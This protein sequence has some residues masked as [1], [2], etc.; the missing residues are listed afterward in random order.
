MFR[1]N[2]LQAIL[3][4][5]VLAI[6]LIAGPT[7]A[8]VDPNG[9]AGPGGFQIDPAMAQQFQQM[10][11]MGQSVMQNMQNSGV[12]PQQFFQEQFQNQ[13]QNGNFDPT[14]IQQSLVDK[15]FMTQDQMDQ[16]QN[17][18]TNLQQNL[19]NQGFGGF[20]QGPNQTNFLLNSIRQ[21]LNVAGDDEWGV[22]APKIQRVL[23]DIQDVR[24]NNPN[25]V[26]NGIVPRILPPNDQS[27]ETP[28]A[29]SWREL[30]EVSQDPQQQDD[31]IR[32]KL[33]AWRQLHA[34]AQSGLNTAQVDLTQF[35]TL[36][37]EA[38]LVVMGIL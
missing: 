8:Q 34:S 12:D 10:Q 5:A 26:S 38:V 23:V 4:A 21:Q 16:A 25:G 19:Q 18:M 24:Q 30:L 15:G 6:G 37:Q 1:R 7:H 9:G 14:A 17:F 35:V 2:Y 27:P 31:T 22:L 3:A 36:R 11:E 28:L 32:A 29:K 33:A 20:Q 13:I